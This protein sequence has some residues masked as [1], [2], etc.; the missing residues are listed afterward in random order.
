MKTGADVELRGFHVGTVTSVQLRYDAATGS[1]STP[2]QIVLEPAQLGIAGAN[3]L[4][5]GDWRPS[6]NGML[7][8]LVGDGLRARLAQNPPLIGSRKV[9]LDFVKGAPAAALVREGGALV[10]PSVESAD[11]DDMTS[12]A[13]QIITK[14]NELPIRETGDKVRSVVARV[15]ALAASPRID[16]SLRHIDRAIAQID[17]TLSQVTPQIAPLVAQLR[18]LNGDA[19]RQNDRPSAL[20]ELSDAARSI[21]V[22]A[23]Y[24]DRHPEALI[25]CKHGDEQ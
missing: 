8:R 24:L 13:D 14:I 1:L 5:D 7:E 6:V 10:I 4:V 9:M 3:P 16:D 23:D 19:T 18:T 22:L 2:V 21:R 12:K 11:I 15:D 20:R 17:H 25:R